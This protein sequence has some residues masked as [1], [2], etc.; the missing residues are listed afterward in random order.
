MEIPLSL[1]F[2]VN[3]Y[4]YIYYTVAP[5][6]QISRGGGVENPEFPTK[7]NLLP[8]SYQN[9]ECYKNISKLI[10]YGIL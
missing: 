3:V 6:G 5:W 2:S 9:D 4:L 7:A 8:D 1:A 10:W